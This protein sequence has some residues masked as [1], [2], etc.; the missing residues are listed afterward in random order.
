MDYCRFILDKHSEVLDEELL[1][2][3][4]KAYQNFLTYYMDLDFWY[5]AYLDTINFSDSKASKKMGNNRR[6]FR[7]TLHSYYTFSGI[8][9]F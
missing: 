6:V 9:T 2:R 5:H 4:E 7:F 8:Q 3:I 1:T